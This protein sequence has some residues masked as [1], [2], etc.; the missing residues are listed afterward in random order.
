MLRR[1]RLLLLAIAVS[2]PCT[3][4]GQRVDVYQR[5]RQAERS[6]D[7]AVSHYRIQLT[8]DEASRSYSGSTRIS[9]RSLRDAL[10]VCVLDAETFTVT[11]VKNDAGEAYRFRQEPGKLSV[12]LPQPLKPGA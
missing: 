2:A 5:P 10:G 9:I 7:Y 4:T 1:F 3:L 12:D 6:R 11:N 8:F